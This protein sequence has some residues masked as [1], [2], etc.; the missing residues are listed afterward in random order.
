MAKETRKKLLYIFL[1]GNTEDV[2]YKKIADKY[3]KSISKKYKNL[4]TG[5]NINA[6]IVKYLY[7]FI[8]DNS[9]SKYDLYVYAFIDKEGARSDVSEFN[10]T[11][12]LK[13]LKKEKVKIANIKEIA[14]IEAIFMIESWFFHDLEGICKYINLECTETLKRNYSNTE[15]FKNTDLVA[16]FRKGKG[17][18]LYRK[19]EESFLNSLDIEKIY[20]NCDDLRRGIEDIIETLGQK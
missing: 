8:K 6:Q 12:I 11:A 13:E 7:H 17:K 18:R 14:A 15:K 16:L 4:K 3:L 19:G 10:A 20:N 9:N 1:E 2:F 5:T